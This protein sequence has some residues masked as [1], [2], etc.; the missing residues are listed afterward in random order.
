MRPHTTSVRSI[1]GIFKALRPQKP[2][3]ACYAMFLKQSSA[4]QRSMA[5]RSQS[6]AFSVNIRIWTKANSDKWKSEWK[7]K[8]LS[9]WSQ[10][11]LTL[12]RV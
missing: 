1:S 11:L 9:E 2:N 10:G 8:T 12:A 3:Y 6:G 7:Q 4:Q 5:V